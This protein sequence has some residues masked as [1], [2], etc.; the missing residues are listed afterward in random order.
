[1]VYIP[2]TAAEINTYATLGRFIRSKRVDQP[3]T[4]SFIRLLNDSCL[5]I[6]STE[7]LDF[8]EFNGYSLGTGVRLE[9]FA[10]K[11]GV[12]WTCSD[13][14]NG[15][16]YHFLWLPT[17]KLEDGLSDR[18][19]GMKGKKSKERWVDIEKKLAENPDVPDGFVAWSTLEKR[20]RYGLRKPAD[21]SSLH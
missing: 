7:R 11:I 1:M 6:S 2:K 4:D 10:N 21:D 19:M 18:I 12:V 5:Y 13:E 8:L 16:P 20:E 3:T 14:D 9:R 17:D 15:P